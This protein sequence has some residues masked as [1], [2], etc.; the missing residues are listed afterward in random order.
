VTTQAPPQSLD[1]EEAVLGAL[2]LSPNAI[3]TVSDELRPDD[4]YRESHRL[5]FQAAIALDVRG[6]PVDA[7]TLVDELERNGTLSEA[8]GRARIH[9]IA[10]LVPPTSNVHRYAEIVREASLRRKMIKAGGDIARLGWDGLGHSDELLAE[11]ESVLSS[12]TNDVARTDFVPLSVDLDQIVADVYHAFETGKPKMGLLTGFVDLD[13][14]TTGFHPGELV[15]IAAR[16]GMGKSVIAQNIAENVADAGGHAAFFALE[17]SKKEMLTRSLARQAGV[18]QYHIRTGQMPGEE[19]QRVHQAAQVIRGR[20]LF[21]EDNPSVTPHELRA[22]ARRL[23]RQAALDVLIV[24]YVQLMMSQ[25]GGQESREREVALISRS[26]KVLAKE[27]EIPVI[28]VCQ[29]NREV[30]YRTNKR[31]HLSDLRESGS[32]E[33]DAD[34]VIFIYRDEYYDPDSEAKG[35]AELIVAKNRHG[36]QDTVKL[37]FV[38][39]KSTFRNLAKGF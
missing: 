33:Q 13:K 36:A 1:A 29:L 15:L 20:N 18:D 32:L 22:R 14:L 37:T 26:L 39:A 16:P 24:D 9:E 30:E 2:L 25:R 6:E 35:I 27:L 21:V 12:V 31:P 7:I 4:F 17:M 8:G 23:Q 28:A 3:A 5:I 10:A 11:A 19:M 34:L 38:G